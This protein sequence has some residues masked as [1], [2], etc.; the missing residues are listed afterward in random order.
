ML[1][2]QP[3]HM[4]SCLL[5]LTL[6]DPMDYGLPGS[7]VHGVLPARKLQ[8]VAM[9]LPDRGFEPESLKS[10]TLAG[11]FFTASATLETLI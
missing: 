2:F 9:G 7:S 6:Y 8:W 5:Y 4:L 11:G 1:I 3:V 10:P